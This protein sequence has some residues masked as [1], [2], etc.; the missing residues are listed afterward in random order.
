VSSGAPPPSGSGGVLEARP[1]E[2]LSLSPG[3]RAAHVAGMATR[4]PSGS[5]AVCSTSAA[6]TSAG[7]YTPY[8]LSADGGV[9]V[10]NPA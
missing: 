2:S 7:Q 5:T 10:W 4:V 8:A 1:N 6:G 3:P 9:V